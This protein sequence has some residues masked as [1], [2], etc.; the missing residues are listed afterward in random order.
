MEVGVY[1][2]VELVTVDEECHVVGREEQV[3]DEHGVAMYVGASEVEQPG[4]V[5]ELGNE[6]A[7][8]F[9]LPEGLPYTLYLALGRLAGKFQRL[10]L[11]LVLG[12]GRPVRPEFFSRVEVCAK[13]YAC[14]AELCPQFLNVFRSVETAV[15]ADRLFI[16]H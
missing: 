4:D 1:A 15:D 11:H 2:F 12:D 16:D 10:N 9:L 8:G 5:V 14:L 13:P 3:A 6:D 7:V